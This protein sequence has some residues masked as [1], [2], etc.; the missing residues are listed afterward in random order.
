MSETTAERDARPIVFASDV[1]LVADGDA[2]T[3]RF[4]TF[5]ESLEGRIEALYCLGDLFHFWLGRGH[6]LRPDYAP[7]LDAFKR[8]ADGGARLGFVWGNRDFLVRGRGFEQRTGFEILG[9]GGS[10][11]FAGRVITVLHGDELCLD[12]VSYQRFRRVIRSWPVMTLERLAP[13]AVKRFVAERLRRASKKAVADKAQKAPAGLDLH[14]DAIQELF[15][16]ETSVAVCG[17]IHREQHRV[18]ARPDRPDGDLYVLG[19]W[20][21][22]EAPFL[23]AEPDGTFRFARQTLDG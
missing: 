4:L 7:V 6:E 1:H 17:H 18:V 8:L 21:D 10:F 20:D 11:E 2:T 23:V 3:A 12:D 22:G 16:G 19:S 13:L 5:L 15:R 9:D 14:P